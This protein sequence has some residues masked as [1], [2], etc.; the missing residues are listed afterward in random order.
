MQEQMYRTA[1]F[2][3]DAPPSKQTAGGAVLGKG[4]DILNGRTLRCFAVDLGAA[5]AMFRDRVHHQ[6]SKFKNLASRHGATLGC[7][8]P[9]I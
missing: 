1:G 9:F 6:E 8:V 2:V 4:G 3:I 7:D 5:N